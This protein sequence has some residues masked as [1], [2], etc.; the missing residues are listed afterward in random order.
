MPSSSAN[1]SSGWIRIG[2]SVR[3]AGDFWLIA[4][5]T[6]PMRE[7]T[8]QGFSALVKRRF[9]LPH[10]HIRVVVELL[11]PLDE[12]SRCRAGRHRPA[13]YL[14][15]EHSAAVEVCANAA[16]EIPTALRAPER[17]VEVRS[18]LAEVEV[19]SAG[20]ASGNQMVSAIREQ[21]RALIGAQSSGMSAA[22][23]RQTATSRN[24][25]VTQRDGLR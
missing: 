15:W 13:L 9:G 7:R 14:R 1:R 18:K 12:V 22:P 8:P 21:E 25:R 20:L 5:S 11:A 2:R 4:P 19:A 10:Q 6:S 24:N 3:V 16:S 23:V 17:A